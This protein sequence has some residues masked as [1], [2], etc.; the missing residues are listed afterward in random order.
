MPQ[1]EVPG[2]STGDAQRPCSSLQP[3][4]VKCWTSEEALGGG[5][6]FDPEGIESRQGGGAGRTKQIGKWPWPQ[7]KGRGSG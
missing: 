1:I 6:A 3:A 7:S 2:G 4:Y 5:A